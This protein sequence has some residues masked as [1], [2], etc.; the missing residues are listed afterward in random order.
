MGSQPKPASIT[1]RCI[2]GLSGISPVVDAEYRPRGSHYGGGTQERSVGTQGRADHDENGAVEWAANRRRR[3]G[4]RA[5]VSHLWAGGIP[6]WRGGGMIGFPRSTYYR[7]PR[8]EP[9]A[10]DG[11][12]TSTGS[13]PL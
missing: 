4:Q 3:D 1:P 2:I 7:R 13:V 11:I 6:V 9:A 5:L 8:G 12:A 10:C